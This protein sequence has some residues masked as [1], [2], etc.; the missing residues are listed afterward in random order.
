MSAFGDIERVFADIYPYRWDFAASVLVFIV[1]LTG[2]GYWKGW[3]H[4]IWRYRLPVGI[5][6]TPMLAL[7]IWLSWSLCSPLF[8]NTTVDEE[9]PFA[10]TA[11]VPANLEREDVELIMSGIAQVDMPVNEPMPTMAPA[12]VQMVAQSAS[13]SGEA[14]LAQLALET[15]PENGEGDTAVDSEPAEPVAASGNRQRWARPRSRRYSTR[16][17]GADEQWSHTGAVDGRS[18]T[19]PPAPT[20]APGPTP[21]ATPQPAPAPTPAPVG[22]VKLKAGQFQDID[23][24]H[25]GSGDATI[26]R[27]PDGS[28]LLRL[29]NFEV[30]NG[31][32]LH[33]ILSP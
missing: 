11:Q 19:Q 17:G 12:P 5:V 22:P 9:F 23:S 15:S 8:T 30:T 6:A 14:P 27:G 7:T 10:S 29:E 28:H 33:V 26:Y 4:T 25:K 3:H 32:D 31:P 21:T 20:S 16:R 1:A 18:P 13:A 2:S 24:F